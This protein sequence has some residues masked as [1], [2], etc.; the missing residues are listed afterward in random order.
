MKEL[1]F[2]VSFDPGTI[3]KHSAGWLESSHKEGPE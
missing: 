3:S 2:D 1:D